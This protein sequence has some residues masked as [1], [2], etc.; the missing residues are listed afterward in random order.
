MAP[1]IDW[2]S[3]A[4]VLTVGGGVGVVYVGLLSRTVRRF[5]VDWT[6]S[7]WYT[8]LPI[9]GYLGILG[10]GV[11]AFMANFHTVELLAAALV[12]VL[13]CGVRNAWDMIITFAMRP[14]HPDHKS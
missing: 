14:R 8:A 13:V 7:L 2:R 3:F 1:S 6:D 11:M 4:A 5:G 12:L 9:V 10:S